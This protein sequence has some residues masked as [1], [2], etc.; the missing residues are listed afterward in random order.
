MRGFIRNVLTLTIAITISIFLV[1]Y[2]TSTLR[3]NN[4][5]ECLK[6]Y[7]GMALHGVIVSVQTGAV[8]ACQYQPGEVNVTVGNYTVVQS[9]KALR[10]ELV[11]QNGKMIAE[12]VAASPEKL[13][14][15]LTEAL[16]RAFS[17]E[18]I[19]RSERKKKM[20][21]ELEQYRGQAGE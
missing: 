18:E 16:E 14:G 6:E 17:V 2:V 15:Q 7:E 5:T 19:E 21:G 1:L 13:A 8:S 3:A 12:G 4:P 20:L 9:G 10:W 11:E